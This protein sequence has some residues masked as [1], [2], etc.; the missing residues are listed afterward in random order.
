MFIDQ[1]G[2][3]ASISEDMHTAPAPT[4]QELVIKFPQTIPPVC[5]TTGLKVHFDE[6]TDRSVLRNWRCRTDEADLLAR[7]GRK[8]FF[9]RVAVLP[10]DNWQPNKR[11]QAWEWA[12]SGPFALH[13]GEY[14]SISGTNGYPYEIV[15]IRHIAPA[16]R[17]FMSLIPASRE[18]AREML[19]GEQIAPERSFIAHIPV[20]SVTHKWILN[21]VRPVDFT[22]EM[23]LIYINKDI[24]MDRS[25]KEERKARKGQELTK[26]SS[27]L[28][29]VAL[30]SVVTPTSDE[31]CIPSGDFGDCIGNGMPT[32]II[33]PVSRNGNCA[34]AV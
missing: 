7:R 6:L 13:I 9:K 10:P 28:S 12:P 15:L 31:S 20:D 27:V 21:G 34:I 8:R 5:Q 24:E 17:C 18:V 33:E 3:L 2:S 19:N 4:E 29:T 22:R 26:S 23:A 14:V 30:S 1:Y 25:Q 32:V 11:P 16:V